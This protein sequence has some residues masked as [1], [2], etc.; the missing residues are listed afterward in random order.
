MEF[1]TNIFDLFLVN[2]F[3]VNRFGKLKNI[4]FC[5][6]V[7]LYGKFYPT[8]LATPTSIKFWFPLHENGWEAA[9]ERAHQTDIALGCGPQFDRCG[10]Q[11]LS[12]TDSSMICS[13]HCSGVSLRS[14]HHRHRHL[15]VGSK[16]K[17][18]REWNRC[19]RL[20]IVPMLRW[21][22]PGRYNWRI[23]YWLDALD[24]WLSCPNAWVGEGVSNFYIIWKWKKLL[25]VKLLT[26][27][28]R[29]NGWKY[30]FFLASAV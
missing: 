7:N 11:T 27:S 30:S 5:R 9:L 29:L 1:K 6:I 25:K 19:N 8:P 4:F 10:L 22:R 23:F 15:S 18:T 20:C 13:W 26:F 21:V 24:K 3:S 16:Y 2:L 28:S 17:P 12:L 14:R